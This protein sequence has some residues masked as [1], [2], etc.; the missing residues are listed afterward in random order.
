M[1]Q[2]Y[3]DQQEN[4]SFASV[5]KNQP[6]TQNSPYIA[7]SIVDGNELIFNFNSHI[8]EDD[9]ILNF[10]PYKLF[11]EKFYTNYNTDR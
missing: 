6:F 3:D 11:I 2:K 5:R 10:S 7:A 8:F 4:Y 1:V 9:L